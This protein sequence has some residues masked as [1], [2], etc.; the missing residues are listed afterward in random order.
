MDLSSSLLSEPCSSPFHSLCSHPCS[1]SLESTWHCH[2]LCTSSH[3][4]Q[5]PCGRVEGGE[6]GGDGQAENGHFL[7][8]HFITAVQPVAWNTSPRLYCSSVCF[9]FEFLWGQLCQEGPR[10]SM[11]SQ[12]ER[13]P[14]EG[15]VHITPAAGRIHNKERKWKAISR[16]PTCAYSSLL[17]SVGDWS[18]EAPAFMDTKIHAQVPYKNGIVFAYDLCSSFCIL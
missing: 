6:W 18:Q 7:P 11:Q 17:V 10:L 15:H 14:A 1:F 13:S 16:K 4:A 8:P 2:V 9:Y 5:T 12:C 3:S